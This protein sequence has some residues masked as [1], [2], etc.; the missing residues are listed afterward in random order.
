[1]SR[2]RWAIASL[3]APEDAETLSAIARVAIAHGHLEH[4]LKM[5]IRK[6]SGLTIVQVLDATKYSNMRDLREIARKLFRQKTNDEEHRLK[7]SSLLQRAERLSNSRNELIHRPWGQ[8]DEG[9]WV[10]KGEDP[11]WG[12]R[13]SVQ[14][15]QE[16]A[17][18]MYALIEELNESHEQ[19]FVSK[20]I[21]RARQN[22]QNLEIE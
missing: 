13:P 18:N 16:L 8:T 9:D 15:L 4:V 10:V 11:R 17:D 6:L 22:R 2:Q 14:E 3:H 21:R 19:G 7:F 12:P 5:T 20:V 1:M